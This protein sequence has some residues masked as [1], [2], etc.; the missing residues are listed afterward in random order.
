MLED[1]AEERRLRPRR[2]TYASAAAAAFR[3]QYQ[4][5]L[6]ERG[7]GVPTWGDAWAG[8]NFRYGR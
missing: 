1:T 5:E 4:Q 6:H 8:E 2:L 7:E 3:K